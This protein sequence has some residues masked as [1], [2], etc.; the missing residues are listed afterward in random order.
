MSDEIL[1]ATEPFKGTG[2]QTINLDGIQMATL[3]IFNDA[4]T[5][6]TF[7]AGKYFEFTVEAGGAFDER[8]DP[9]E[10]LVITAASGSYRGYCR[11]L[12]R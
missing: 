8:M 11:K 1:Y 9:F 7:K 2:V 10:T 5:E 4:E 3:T 12:V 6:L